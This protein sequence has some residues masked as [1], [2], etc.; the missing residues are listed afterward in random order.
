MNHS[1]GNDD[2]AV[3]IATGVKAAMVICVLGSIVLIAD[4]AFVMPSEHAGPGPAT[5][6]MPSV[7]APLSPDGRFDAHAPLPAFA[8]NGGADRTAAAPEARLYP[9]PASDA[10]R[11][12]DGHPPSF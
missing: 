9:E 7:A 2:K 8:G 4:R 6:R 12:E 1:H 10:V 3:R 11:D 5:L